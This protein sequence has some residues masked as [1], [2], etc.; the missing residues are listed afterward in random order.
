MLERLESFGQST[1]DQSRGPN[2]VEG[3]SALKRDPC[4]TALPGGA[5][6]LQRSTIIYSRT[7][8]SSTKMSGAGYDV[9]VDVDEEVNTTHERPCHNPHSDTNTG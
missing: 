9:V 8:L 3:A 6:V 1:V 5:A 7:S 2:E 4:M